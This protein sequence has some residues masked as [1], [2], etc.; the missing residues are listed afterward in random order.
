V[1][2]II[3]AHSAHGRGVLS[4]IGEYARAQGP[5]VFFWDLGQPWSVLDRMAEANCAGVIAAVH[6]QAQADALAKLDLPVIN[7]Q[8]T[9]AEAPFPLVYYDHLAIG[10][11]AGEHL[12]DRGLE[13]FA[14]VGCETYSYSE[15][16]RDAFVQ[17]VRP[18]APGAVPAF[19]LLIGDDIY[20]AFKQLMAWMDELPKP[21]GIAACSDEHARYAYEAAR[22]LNL[23]VPDDVAIIGV[24]DDS[25]VIRMTDPELSSIKLPSHGVGFHAAKWLDQMMA[26]KPL[27]RKVARLEP[28]GV[29]P[30]RSTDV[31]VTEDADVSAAIRYIRANAHRPI[32]VADVLN[33]VPMSRRTLE[34]RFRHYLSRSPQQEI[35]R[36]HIDRARSLL[37]E[38]DL[39]MPEIARNSGFGNADRLAVVFGRDVG[40][41]PSAYRQRFRR[42]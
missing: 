40:M 25:L 14:Y 2:L 32:Q 22:W 29:A 28:I 6:T 9:L 38:T 36:V 13:R 10:R 37:A 18:D 27:A 35:Q 1:A 19:S 3:E 39:S 33:A 11:L 23:H 4:G 7:V 34:R 41:T 20:D 21:I 31:M 15:G 42:R 26:G 24:D 17:T 16:R 8:D 12:K 5:W 30:R